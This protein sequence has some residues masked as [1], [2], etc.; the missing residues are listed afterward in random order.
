MK[1]INNE[2][3]LK[4][5]EEAGLSCTALAKETAISRS[6]IYNMAK[7]QHCPSH[8]IMTILAKFLNIS[9]EDFLAIFFNNLEF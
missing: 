9:A 4:Y 8:E 6:T 1:V 7:G 5:L 3:L 2:L